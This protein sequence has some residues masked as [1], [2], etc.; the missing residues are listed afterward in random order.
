M[1]R[2]LLKTPP[3]GDTAQAAGRT[4]HS[5]HLG[6][7]P[8]LNRLLTR[9]RLEPILRD[10]LPPEDRRSRISPAQGL[11]V[12]LKNLL[13]SREPLYGVPQWAARCDPAALGLAPQQIAALND[14]RIGRCLD[15]LFR[16]DCGSLALAVA[17]QAIAEFD[18]ELDEL[19]ND[20][21]TVTFS[22]AYLDAARETKRRGQTRL[23]ITWGHNKDHRPDLKQLLFILTVAKDGGVPVYFQAK[24]GNV[25][26]DRTHRSTWDLLCKLTGRLDFLYVADC[27]LANTENM[28]YVHG[29]GGRFLTVLPRTR[30]ED[31]TFREALA[32]GR[33]RWRWVHDKYDEEGKL[34]D[35]FRV[36]EPAATSVEG[37][38]LEWYHSTRKAELDALARARQLERTLKDMAELQQKLTS[39]RTRY[40]W[41]AKVTEA[42]EV[43][44]QAHGTMDWIE[45]EIEEHEQEIFRQERRG[46]P[47][48]RTRYRRQVKSRFELK[49]ALNHA[50]LASAAVSDG[51]FP[52]ITND[53][54]LSEEALL[55][56]YKGQPVIEK[57]FE[58]L[59]T[60]FEVAPVFLKEASRIQ[61]L[62]CLYFFVLLVQALLERELRRAMARHQIA[63]LP[64]YPEGRAC[65]RPTTPQL[66]ELFEN[67][68][69]HCLV[70]GNK[71]PVV[72][73]TKLSK[74]QRRIVKLLGMRM[75]YDN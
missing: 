10:Y 52:L 42:V 65:R 67:V 37:Y 57:R 7:L 18:V 15:Q 73:T 43:I 58:Q 46:R 40:R 62:L 30:S 36:S 35:Q 21:T 27:K 75:V 32:G 74:L 3:L 64:L 63:S 66:I 20:S 13:L 34:A 59:K 61:A 68:Q 17:T 12:L 49:Y 11:M 29:H 2:P 48:D 22:G 6:L 9:L 55:L 41:R 25:V 44:L 28:A 24:S 1:K 19:H 45:L 26:D 56:A 60:E 14:D 8:I 69:R 5:Y 71:P 31:R 4:L 39:P 47:N 50:T 72:M 51:V 53:R 54:Q 23:A 38:R 70:V 16:S 33:V